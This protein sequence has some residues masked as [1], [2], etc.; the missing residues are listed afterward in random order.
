MV[1]RFIIT[2]APVIF[3]AG[4]ATANRQPT[5]VNQLQIRIAQLEGQMDAQDQE[6]AALKSNISDLTAGSRTA[7]QA[8][9]YSMNSPA[10]RID[11]STSKAAASQE[12]Q[13][14]RVAV[15]PQKVQLALQSA[16]YYKGEIDGKLGSG[17]QTAIKA[18]QADHNLKSDGIV[19]EKT[20][21]Q[22]KSYLE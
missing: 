14:L 22:L 19:G 20:W 6:I 7:S 13:I 18:F 9:Q 5:A 11:K 16:G 3:L 8:S 10:T 17:S 1:K 15:T 12:G 4:C 2:V 21:T